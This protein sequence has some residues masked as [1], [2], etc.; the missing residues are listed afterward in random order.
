MTR[1]TPN[2]SLPRRR[3]SDE[4]AKPFGPTNVCRL[5]KKGQI[6]LLSNTLI[7]IDIRAHRNVNL[8]FFGPTATFVGPNGFAFSSEPAGGAVKSGLGVTLS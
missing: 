2:R 4:K 7:T 8:A 6:T 1:V 5:T 3:R